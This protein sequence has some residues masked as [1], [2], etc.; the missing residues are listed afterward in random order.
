MLMNEITYTPEV[1]NILKNSMAKA[2]ENNKKKINIE[3]IFY[4]LLE[5]ND[6][7]SKYIDTS[8]YKKSSNKNT[9]DLPNIEYY[10]IVKNLFSKTINIAKNN[11]SKYVS[12]NHLLLALLEYKKIK[13]ICDIENIPHQ[14][15]KEELLKKIKKSNL[16]KKTVD[17]SKNNKIQNSM[18]ESSEKS[19]NLL[20]E[21]FDVLNYNIDS[22][23]LSREKEID[24]IYKILA[25]KENSNVLILGKAGVGKTNLVKGFVNSINSGKYSIFNETTV[26]SLKTSSVIS[27]CILRGE[28]EEKLTKIL[29]TVSSIPNIIIFID[30]IHSIFNMGN[31]GENSLNFQNILKPFISNGSIKVIG[32]TT[33]KEYWGTIKKDKAFSDRFD[34]LNLKEPTPKETKLILKKSLDNYYDFHKINISENNIDLLVDFCDQFLNKD[35]FPRK[36]FKFLDF[37]MASKKIKVFNMPKNFSSYD[38]I[39]ELKRDFK[40]KL[41]KNENVN[42]SDLQKNILEKF[43]EYQKSYKNYVDSIPKNK[44]SIN[45]R[46]L[47][48]GFKEYA[49]IS[50]NQIDK[51]FNSEKTKKIDPKNEEKIK[52][53]IFGQDSQIDHICQN[54][55]RSLFGFKDPIQPLGVYMLIGPT[56][57]GKTFFAR[58]IA[59][60]YFSRDSFLKINMS[61][62]EESHSIYRLI[63]SNPG[64]VGYEDSNILSIFFEKH[65]EGVILFDEIEK[66]HPKVFDIFLQMFED[67]EL[68]LGNGDKLNFSNFL[69]LLTGNI[70]SKFFEKENNSVGFFESKDNTEEIVISEVKKTFR[71]EFI[72]RLDD[73]VIFNKLHKDQAREIVSNEINKIINSSNTDTK[74]ISWD[75]SI[76]DFIINK[77]NFEIYGGRNV[78]K[79]VSKYFFNKLYLFLSSHNYKNKKIGSK[80]Q[81]DSVIFYFAN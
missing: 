41:E 64:Y 1:K 74:E 42:F 71:P 4:S 7:V 76:A 28:F 52:Q 65:K 2:L 21:Y 22:Y 68:V 46:D 44:L 62:Y 56:G 32:A 10:E 75:N 25:Q 81:N 34:I 73:I 72:N 27:G 40:K 24:H 15:I 54:L 47:L 80:I 37:L 77:S 49:N 13:D 63:G 43:L 8:K 11:N 66:A 26:L 12:T 17:I 45:K 38:K 18:L 30:E 29:E 58:E 33:E 79:T 39:S 57:V 35:A 14:Q 3:D 69:I 67:G 20:A 51:F 48:S 61:E 70:G 23:C 6:L 50:E 53:N 55:R 5:N 9:K 19:F 59:D 16:S 31:N 78:K 60:K 36:A